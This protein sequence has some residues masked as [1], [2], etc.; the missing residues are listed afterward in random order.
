MANKIIKFIRKGFICRSSCPARPKQAPLKRSL[1]PTSFLQTIVFREHIKSNQSGP[2]KK[3]QTPPCDRFKYLLKTTAV[4]KR[5]LTLQHVTG[6]Y[7]WRKRGLGRDKV[8]GFLT[9]QYWILSNRQKSTMIKGV[10]A[11]IL[12]GLRTEERYLQDFIRRFKVTNQNLSPPPVRFEVGTERDYWPDEG[13]QVNNDSLNNPLRWH[14]NSGK[15]QEMGKD[16]EQYKSF[17]RRRSGDRNWTYLS[18]HITLTYGV[19]L[20]A[21]S[22]I[23]PFIPLLFFLPAPEVSPSPAKRIHPIGRTNEAAH[24]GVWRACQHSL[25]VPKVFW[26]GKSSFGPPLSRVV[27]WGK[28]DLK[29]AYH[30]QS[31]GKKKSR[32][33]DPQRKMWPQDARP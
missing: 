15:Y 33:N 1:S 6:D 26:A 21:I 13:V 25:L 3:L 2:S 5:L 7:S 4:G 12:T 29:I 11:Y 17:A 19:K 32:G 22:H 16:G 28:K 24:E 23:F 8:S 31:R 27:L 10:W 18:I 14:I 30:R 9:Q 20:T